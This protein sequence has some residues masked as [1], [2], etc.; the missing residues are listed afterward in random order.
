MQHCLS[1]RWVGKD[2]KC[3]RQQCACK[4][5]THLSNLNLCNL[6]SLM[7]ILPY[8]DPSPSFC[9]GAVWRGA[10]I[11]LPGKYVK[12]LEAIESKCEPQLYH[13]FAA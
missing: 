5:H 13:P 12:I 8:Y 10:S 7:L 6:L 2:S 1:S 3:Y 9:E 4:S 11:S